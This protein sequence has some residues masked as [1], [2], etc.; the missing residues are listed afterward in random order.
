MAGV[1]INYPSSAVAMGIRGASLASLIFDSARAAFRFD[2][3]RRS[4]LA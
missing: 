4:A 2:R 3:N 1:H